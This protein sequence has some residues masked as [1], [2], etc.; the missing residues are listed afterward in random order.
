MAGTLGISFSVEGGTSLS[1]GSGAEILKQLTE[2]T[3]SINQKCGDRFVINFDVSKES[4]NKMLSTIRSLTK[5]M[6]ELSRVQLDNISKS[7]L[8]SQINKINTNITSITKT[9]SDGTTDLNQKLGVTLTSINNIAKSLTSISG[10]NFADSVSQ[11]A[12]SINDLSAKSSHLKVSDLADS[13]QFKGTASEADILRTKVISLYET[14]IKLRDAFN[15]TNGDNGLANQLSNYK[16]LGSEFQSAMWFM[17]QF[18]SNS[19]SN[20]LGE[21][22]I[23][24]LQNYEQ[25]LETFIGKIKDIVR[26]AN[27]IGIEG[28]DLSKFNFGDLNLNIS[29][30]I[31]TETDLVKARLVEM[32]G[33]SSDMFTKISGA[34]QLGNK[35]IKAQ[36]SSMFVDMDDFKGYVDGLIGQNGNISMS[37]V[38]NT[39]DIGTLRQYEARISELYNTLKTVYDMPLVGNK[40]MSFNDS[41]GISNIDNS[42]KIIER[43]G[44]AIN[45]MNGSQVNFDAANIDKFATEVA[46]LSTTIGKV[47]EMATGLSTAIGSLGTS[48]SSINLG[49]SNIEQIAQKFVYVDTSVQNLFTDIKTLA[50][51]FNALAT[52]VAELPN[53]STVFDESS[54]N[55]IKSMSATIG[56]IYNGFEKLKTAIVGNKDWQTMW[57]SIQT[58]I[59]TGNYQIALAGIDPQCFINLTSEIQGAINQ[60]SYTALVGFDDA[61]A[62]AIQDSIQ[63]AI[64]AGNYT[65]S[66]V[67][68]SNGSQKIPSG[69]GEPMEVGSSQHSTAVKQVED[70]MRTLR[71][72]MDSWTSSV[73]STEYTSLEIAYKKLEDIK[74]L[75]D[76]GNISN[77]D[78]VQEFKAI[79]ASVAEAHNEINKLNKDTRLLVTDKQA[80][81]LK[82]SYTRLKNVDY[83][84]K[85]TNKGFSANDAEVTN[86]LNDYTTLMS[87]MKQFEQNGWSN[88]TSSEY[89]DISKQVKDLADRYKDLLNTAEKLKL[90]TQQSNNT[91]VN[92]SEVSKAQASISDIYAKLDT[93]Q[94]HKIVD[95]SEIES[96]RTTVNGIATKSGLIAQDGSFVDVGALQLTKAQLQEINEQLSIAKSNTSILEDKNNIGLQWNNVATG[97]ENAISKYKK[98][99]SIAP[100]AYQK[101]IDLQKQL[102]N[103]T[104]TGSLE[105]A[106]KELNKI[107]NEISNSKLDGRNIFQQLFGTVNLVSVLRTSFRYIEKIVDKVTELDSLVTDLQVAT[108]YSRDYAKEM[109]TS[110]SKLGQEL[111]ASTSTVASAADEWLRQGYSTEESQTL[112]KASTVLSKLGQIE[113]DEATTALTATMKSYGIAVEDVMKIV[114]KFT[115]V[116]MEAATSAGDIATALSE[117]A[118]SAKVA[119]VPLDKLIGYISTIS[120]VSQDSAE[121]VGTFLKTM[122]G[123]MGNIKTGY[124]TDP[125][126][127]DDISN[128]ESALKSNGVNLRD[129][130]GDFRDFGT[131]LDEVAGKWDSYSE[132]QKRAI[133]V[134]IGSTRNQ[135]KFFVLMEHY[136]EAMGYADTASG[137]SGTAMQKYTDAYLN[138]VE[139][140]KESASA[141]LE[142]V[143][144][145][146]LDTDIISN[147]YNAA[148]G[149]F[150]LLSFL[151]NIPIIGGLKGLIPVLTSLS[152]LFLQN[153]KS[154]QKFLNSIKALFVQSEKTDSVKRGLKLIRQNGENAIF[155][156]SKKQADYDA[157]TKYKSTHSSL[158]SSL[159]SLG[160]TA[161]IEAGIWAISKATNLATEYME[162]LSNAISELDENKS[163]IESVEDKI[164][165]LNDQIKQFQAG[166]ISVS[167]AANITSLQNE[168]SLQKAKLDLLKSQTEQ[169]ERQAVIAANKILNNAERGG[170]MTAFSV[171][172]TTGEQTTGWTKAWNNFKQS[173]SN[174]FGDGGLYEINSPYEA[175]EILKN[176]AKYTEENVESAKSYYSQLASSIEGAIEYDDE[177][178]KTY[179]KYVALASGVDSTFANISDIV[180]ENGYETVKQIEKAYG[181]EGQE[182]LT[183]YIDALAE[184]GIVSKDMYGQI[185][186]DS[187]ADSLNVLFAQTEDILNRF[188]R[189]QSQPSDGDLMADYGINLKLIGSA[190]SNNLFGLAEQLSEGTISS[191]KYTEAINEW[192]KSVQ[193]ADYATGEYADDL[194][195]LLLLF[196]MIIPKT[197]ESKNELNTFANGLKKVGNVSTGLD[198]LSEIWND[199]EDGGGFDY[200]NLFDSDFAEQF[201]NYTDEYND[202]IETVANN[203]NDLN[204][205]KTAFNNLVAAYLDGEQALGGLTEE[206]KKAAIAWLKQMNVTNAAEVVENRLNKSFTLTKKQYNSLN[207]EI[208]GGLNVQAD[209]NGKFVVLKSTLIQL[210]GSAEKAKTAYLNMISAMRYG[211]LKSL[212]TE[213]QGY[214]DEHGNEPLIVGDEHLGTY[215]SYHLGTYA[216]YYGKYIEKYQAEV[217]ELEKKWDNYTTPEFG[218]KSDDDVSADTTAADLWEKALSKKKHLLEMDKI[219]EKE[220]YDWVENNYK[221]Y[222]KSTGDTA[223]EYMAIQEELYDYKKQKLDTDTNTELTQIE[224]DKLKGLISEEE[225]QKKKYQINADAYTELQ[226]LIKDGM[227]GVDEDE[228]LE[229][230]NQYLQNRHDAYTEEFEYEKSLLDDNL[231]MNLITEEQY[232]VQ[233]TALVKKYYE[234]S[235]EYAEE[236]KELQK[237]LYDEG[238]DLMNKWAEIAEKAINGVSDATKGVVE[239][240]ESLVNGLVEANSSNF[241]LEKNL[242]Q[243]ALSMNYISEEDYYKQLESL[244][245]SYYGAKYV[246]LEEYW[247]NQEEIYEYERQMLED[248]A[249]AVEDIHAKVVE[250]IKQELE[251]AKDAIEE[252]KD[253]YLDL[254]DIRKEALEDLQDEDDYEKERAEKLNT[255]AELQRQLNALAYDTSASGMRKYKEVYAELIDAQK[256][257]AEFEQD[258]AYDVAKDNLDA[259]K[260]AIENSTTTQTDAIDDKLND[261][262]WLVQE[263]WNRLQGMSDELYQA[264]LDYNKKYSTS[265]KDDITSSWNDAIDAA[266]KYGEVSEENYNTWEDMI[267]NPTKYE[268]LDVNTDNKIEYGLDSQYVQEKQMFNI[269]EVLQEFAGNIGDVVGDSTSTIAE[270][271]EKMFQALGNLPSSVASVLNTGVSNFGTISA[272]TLA[273]VSALGGANGISATLGQIANGNVTMPITNDALTGFVSQASSWS[274]MVNAITQGNYSLS[275]STI[276]Q[277]TSGDASTINSLNL[278]TTAVTA[279]TGSTGTDV[280]TILNIISTIAGSVGTSGSTGTS[281]VLGGLLSLIATGA[282]ILGGLN[283]VSTNV[284]GLQ[285]D[286]N[287]IATSVTSVS[288]GIISLIELTKQVV[289][290][291][292]DV[293]SVLSTLTSNALTMANGFVNVIGTLSGTNSGSTVG[294]AVVSGLG[295]IARSL[296]QGSYAKGTSNVPH[297]GIYQTDELG[298]ELKFIKGKSGTYSM[299]T[300][301]SKVLTAGATERLMKIA[302]NPE[303]LFGNIKGAELDGLSTTISPS[304]QQK[305]NS[306]VNMTNTFNIKSSDPNGVANEIKKLLPTIADYT[307]GNIVNNMS[308]KG[309][310]RKVTSLI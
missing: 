171:D 192:K 199:I 65:V 232:Y 77:S 23:K 217:D 35:Q 303:L 202:F 87:K 129:S 274:Q 123:R 156:D 285:I 286:Q 29:D 254:I 205:V 122:F 238:M 52:E 133:A 297:S 148:E 17:Q 167:D 144:N 206:N 114:D 280:S 136:D 263:A 34:Y 126:S 47:V 200:S 170:G 187:S 218:G 299:L 140:A 70:E 219:T 174:I 56:E 307:M 81:S 207:E 95:P 267:N 189:I 300:K 193:N 288:N 28:F 269:I 36:I 197:E 130:N 282:S 264:L 108:G 194:Q 310:K 158:K 306:N 247:E 120:E 26:N 96:I 284:G 106:R 271:V 279:L 255:I 31:A 175:S 259:E 258:R 256:E 4:Y 3:N 124:L 107:I 184:L 43:L 281:T 216:S 20:I 292:A 166:E 59:N 211:Q 14:A 273:M 172:A 113:S 168:I 39:S 72:K 98:L 54:I 147:V 110:Y 40:I 260:E 308:N 13:A 243:H 105:D 60:G 8:A 44:S 66:F 18:N 152:V 99:E 145:S 25:N 177:I 78:F 138:S 115:A 30:K 251:D 41:A 246:Y 51:M 164:T 244:Y 157:A 270:I 141:A 83:K 135:E 240:F 180:S 295:N 50:E 16:R 37:D 188:K 10:K 237:E 228:R 214:V 9:L 143:A 134:A 248:G 74:V 116:D 293:N 181:T 63:Q 235:S 283:G 220:Y 127:G 93:L 162:D 276:L 163:S 241:D 173:F 150:N 215:A 302:N 301:G 160:I 229:A 245:K 161:A 278:L 94:N 61:S 32:V 183:G 1:S 191:E 5:E 89:K 309:V 204:A 230:E 90:A 104:Y 179:Y 33:V 195:T 111:G 262:E 45:I 6:N 101:L 275:P 71:S 109:L 76:N 239:A 253:E 182:A 92:A 67:G 225:Y 155:F 201:S 48:L 221:K 73:G 231:D 159:I 53:M 291:Q 2:I 21:N 223:D 210:A 234:N 38:I 196:N 117:T 86:F 165:D 305:N 132:A 296:I 19:M 46:T 277:L 186:W 142:E 119:N 169:L 12:D 100:E 131:V 294:S 153:S 103:G 79:K 84:S 226:K 15:G 242:L 203:P 85:L 80:N 298:E 82:S 118:T 289:T 88:V 62:K 64:D 198:M 154:A 121:S 227:Y 75:L 7:S 222:L 151:N 91:I 287:N 69:T 146:F 55:S 137:S 250:L 125:E 27:T 97:V 261:N 190:K 24:Q 233:L 212:I 178:K 224:N 252:T 139:A 57:T 58:A 304:L 290:G 22:N 209:A 213:L 11:I 49:D 272:S 128:V 102:S 249:T 176:Q 112:I 149:L 42:I 68:S 266:N 257:L 208:G 268:G 236:Y 185:D 265:I